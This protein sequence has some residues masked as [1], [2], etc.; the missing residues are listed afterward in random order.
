MTEREKEGKEEEREREQEASKADYLSDSQRVLSDKNSVFR[1][2]QCVIPLKSQNVFHKIGS[3]DYPGLKRRIIAMCH[4]REDLHEGTKRV[5][6]FLENTFEMCS[7]CSSE[8]V[9]P[10]RN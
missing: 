3:S 6:F 9:T 8:R 5:G 10:M 1:V 2:A 7:P 4:N